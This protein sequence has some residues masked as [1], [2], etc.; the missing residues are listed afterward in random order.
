LTTA[1]SAWLP[2]LCL[3]WFYSSFIDAIYKY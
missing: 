1:L 3:F 2:L